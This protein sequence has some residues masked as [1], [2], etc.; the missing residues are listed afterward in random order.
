MVQHLV[1]HFFAPRISFYDVEINRIFSIYCR[2]GSERKD[3]THQYNN[4]V[5]ISNFF[6]ISNFL[7]ALDGLKFNNLEC[8]A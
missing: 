7:L 4:S 2:A 5:L 1:Y 8:N 3:V 6:F